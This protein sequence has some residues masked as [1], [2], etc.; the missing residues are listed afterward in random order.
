MKIKKIIINYKIKMQIF[1]TPVIKYMEYFSFH[2]L[3][4]T[5]AMYVSL[6]QMK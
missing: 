6:I 2:D 5:F 3:W 1:I 4:V